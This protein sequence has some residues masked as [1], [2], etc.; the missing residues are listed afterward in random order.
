MQDGSWI[1]HY[2]KTL[3]SKRVILHLRNKD[4]WK[5]HWLIGTKLLWLNKSCTRRKREKKTSI[6]SFEPYSS[7][8]PRLEIDLWYRD[9]P[10]NNSELGMRLVGYSLRSTSRHNCTFSVP[11]F[12]WL[13]C[14]L[15]ALFRRRFME[16][17]TKVSTFC[18][19]AV[20][21]GQL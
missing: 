21:L 16:N 6:W 4:L 7:A 8:Q 10:Y 14:K 19:P 12:S 11:S 2:M 9:L 13:S 15:P 1:A 18:R 3:K 5:K 17:Q 20:A